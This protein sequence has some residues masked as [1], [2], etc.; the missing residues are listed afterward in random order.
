MCVYF[1]SLDEVLKDSYQVVT[2]VIEKGRDEEVR[3]I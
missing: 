1:M 3:G 2:M